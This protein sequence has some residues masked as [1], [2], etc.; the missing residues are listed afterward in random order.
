MK[1]PI[2]ILILVNLISFS[3]N[4]Y[5]D[6][7]VDFQVIERDNTYSIVHESEDP[8]VTIIID[9][10]QKNLTTENILTF[11]QVPRIQLIVKE[12]LEM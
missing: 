10:L 9:D 6:Q 1:V 3:S 5:D 12:T 4:S 2:V 11:L 7:I 8:N